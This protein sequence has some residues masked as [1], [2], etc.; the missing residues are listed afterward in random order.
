MAQKKIVQVYNGK[1]GALPVLKNGTVTKTKS[2]SHN[3]RKTN[4]STALVKATPKA[5]Q[6]TNPASI[7]SRS[8]PA[9]EAFGRIGSLLADT[10]VGTIGALAARTGTDMISNVVQLPNHP[11]ARPVVTASLA[12]FVTAPLAKKLPVI[13]KRSDLIMVGGLIAAGLDAA[14]AML[15][16]VTNRIRSAGRDFGRRIAGDTRAV[17]TTPRT[18][19]PDAAA[20]QQIVNAAAEGAAAAV[21]T[22]MSGLSG[23][24]DYAD[25]EEEV[26]DEEE[27]YDEELAY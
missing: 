19:L 3:T 26:F 6:K 24:N 22:T 10:A 8:N 20:Q 14:D 9:K 21:A 4:G 1:G 12:V 5:P 13:G 27:V 11:L 25:D 18:A 16:D 7:K 17:A 23:G 2:G 15:P